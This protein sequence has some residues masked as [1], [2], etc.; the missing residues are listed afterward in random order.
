MQGITASETIEKLRDCFARFGIPD[1]IVSDNATQFSSSDFQEF[2]SRNGIRHMTSPP[3][4]PQSNGAAENSVKTFKT[5]MT[6]ALR[7]PENSSTPIE[8]LVSRH[9]F[10]Y[11]QPE[12]RHIN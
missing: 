2:C 8:T 7:D 3:Y 12:K 9:L 6:K 10:Y 11:R 1:L 5:A 4:K